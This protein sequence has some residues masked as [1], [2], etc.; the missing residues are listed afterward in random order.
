[1]ANFF[2]KR[3]QH[4]RAWFLNPLVRFQLAFE[5]GFERLRSAYHSLLTAC[6][7]RR[8]FFLPAFLL[9]CAA[10]FLLMPWLG[11]DFFPN[12][13]SGQFILHLRAKSG[14]RIE[15]TA[16]LCDLVEGTIRQEIPAS[17]VDNILDNIGLPYSTVNFMHSTSGLI[18]A[19]DADVLVSLKDGHHATADYIQSL[20]ETLPR[21]YPGTTFYFLPS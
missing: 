11:Q 20:R 6:V 3:K 7:H 10:A 15:E 16:E 8:G 1:M 9:A 17:E 21:E 5:R 14:T 13:D 4:V 19:G 12:T 18:G 2:R